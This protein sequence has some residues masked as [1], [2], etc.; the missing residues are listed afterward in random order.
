MSY[1]VILA[2]VTAWTKCTGDAALACK[3]SF[4]GMVLPMLLFENRYALSDI[5]L[6]PQPRQ[7]PATAGAA[8]VAGSQH[9]VSHPNTCSGIRPLC[10]MNNTIT[11]ML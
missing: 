2:A 11:T 6:L 10:L 1:H 7:P 3:E 8:A 5:L 4:G 9:E